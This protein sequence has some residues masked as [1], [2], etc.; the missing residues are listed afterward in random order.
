MT[1]QDPWEDCD[2]V[3]QVATAG[4]VLNDVVQAVSI[5]TRHAARLELFQVS[6]QVIIYEEQ[7]KAPLPDSGQRGT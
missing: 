2:H 1:I 3:F 4:I 6:V 5:R 7:N